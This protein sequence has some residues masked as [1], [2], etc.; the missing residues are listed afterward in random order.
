MPFSLNLQLPRFVTSTAAAATLAG[1]L[2]VVLGVLLVA[3][4]ILVG[5]VVVLALALLGVYVALTYP[6]IALGG[7]VILM[8]LIPSYAAPSVGSL[9][10][11][12]AAGASWLLIVVLAWRNLAT[13]GRIMRVTSVDYTVLIFF[14]LMAVSLAFSPRTSF[15]DYKNLIFIWFGP[16]LGM[17]LLLSECKHPVKVVSISFALAMAVLAPIAVSEVLGGSNPFFNLDFNSTEFSVWASQIARF[18]QTRAVASFGHPIAFSM[19]LAA[20]ALFCLAMAL[21]NENRN[22][23]FFWYALAAVAVGVQALALSRTGWVMIGIG[24]VAIAAVN[25]KGPVRKRLITLFAIA[26]AVILVVSVVMPHELSVLPGFGHKTEANY[27][28]SGLYREKLLE[29]ATEPGV[30]GLWGNT[31]NQVTPYVDYGTATD[32]AYIILADLWGLIPTFALFAIGGSLIYTV[33]RAYGQ[34][35]EMLAILPIVAFTSLVAIFFVAFITQQQVMIWM[36]IGAAGVAAERVS[37]QRRR[38][39][40]QRRNRVRGLA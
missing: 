34:E 27:A 22:R 31:T 37:A 15:S 14:A 35:G 1:V 17:R 13:K 40:D 11:F 9:L 5:L 8:A 2:G 6:E 21:S 24:I 23:R 12:P 7:L 19:F 32:N 4:P 16:Y 30:L 10:F 39:R 3:K 28:S 20:A 18:G 29:R 36:L 26:F 38:E 33:V 25:V